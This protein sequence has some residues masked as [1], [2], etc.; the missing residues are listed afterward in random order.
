MVPGELVEWQRRLSDVTGREVR[1]RRDLRGY[2]EL[3]QRRL[4]MLTAKYRLNYVIVRREAVRKLGFERIP[5]YE[6]DR[7][8]VY[9]L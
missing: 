7:F 4:R 2:N 1:S 6:D 9:R 5:A 8:V 3:D